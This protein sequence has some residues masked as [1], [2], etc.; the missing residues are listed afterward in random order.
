MRKAQRNNLVEAIQSVGIDPLDF[1]VQEYDD[2]NKVHIKHRYTSSWFNVCFEGGLFKGKYVVGDNPEWLVTPS[3]TWHS[4]FPK[5]ITW[6]R[7]VKTDFETPDKLAEL[8]KQVQAL[9]M[10]SDSIIDNTPFTSDEQKQIEGKL[11]M[12]VEHAQRTYSL[13]LAQVK[14][15]N[16]KL[17]YVVKASRR[18]GRKDWFLL[19]AG[20][21]FTYVPILL[22]PEAIRDMSLSLLKAIGHL[23]GFSDFPLL[24]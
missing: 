11:Q 4:M 19:F 8:Q 6:L 7:E 18:L 16:D 15:F 12:M 22:P 3:T 10:A 20:A 23:H 1:E 2:V 24:P 21:I 9:S 13:S 17:D 5:I 14:A